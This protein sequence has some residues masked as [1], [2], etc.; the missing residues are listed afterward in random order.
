MDPNMMPPGAPMDPAMM[1]GGMPPGAPMDPAM[2][3][4]GPPPGP[5]TMDPEIA[6]MMDEQ[7]MLIAQ[8]QE[9]MEDL[10]RAIE[11]LQ[12]ENETL[13]QNQQQQQQEMMILRAELEA[14]KSSWDDAM[15]MP[16]V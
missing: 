4:G 14:M 12:A 2:M 6:A 15:T 16:G 11:D 9:T 5:P 13:M 10:V 3:Q 8:N 7:A 1:Q